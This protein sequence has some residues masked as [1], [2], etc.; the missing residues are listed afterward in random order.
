MTV[1]SHLI[2]AHLITAAEGP[3]HPNLWNP[4]ILGVLVVLSAIGLFCGSVYLLLSTNLGAR[5]GFLVAFASLAGF[6]VL[7]S[8]LWWSSGNSGIDPP[9][10]HSPT[11]RVVEVV[12]DPQ[13]SKIAAVHNIAQGG[14]AADETVLA[15]LRPAIDAALVTAPKIANQPPVVQPLAKFAAS[16]DYLTDF[17]G[18]QTYITG[19][20]TKNV[21]WH[22]PRYAAV[23]FCPTL[24]PTPPGAAPTC[25]PLQDKSYAI[26]SY[27]FGSLREPV[28]FQFWVPS[29]LLF[30]LSLLGLHWY[31]LD[32]RK[33]KRAGL[34]PVP[35]TPG[36]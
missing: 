22:Y 18:F 29:V 15:N 36:T 34:A 7:L 31:E 4:T 13:Q 26:L 8:T 24:T 3:A 14:K 5:L 35:T 25:D 9:H 1:T 23:Q 19:G 6:M 20:G 28:V 32:Q 33:R 17:K 30:G 12:S 16:L 27:N 2:N 10:G 21:F 11:W